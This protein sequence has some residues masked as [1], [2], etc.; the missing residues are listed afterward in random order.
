M[1][2][3]SRG[4]GHGGTALDPMTWDK[5]GILKQGMPRL[6]MSIDLASLPG[7]IT[8]W[9]SSWCPHGS[10]FIT[11]EDVAGWPYSVNLLLD[12]YPFLNSLR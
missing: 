4:N 11:L 7:P 9:N 10:G 8:F 6:R 5:G 3:V 2:A 12:S 1:V